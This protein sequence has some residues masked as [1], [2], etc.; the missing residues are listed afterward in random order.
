VRLRRH[1]RLCRL[2]FEIRLQIYHYCI[3]RKYVIRVSSPRFYIQRLFQEKDYPVDLENV[4]DFEDD[5]LGLEGTRELGFDDNI[6]NSEADVVYSLGYT[7][8][9]ESNY[10]NC[11]VILEGC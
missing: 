6:E 1:L 7:F 4:L 8:D 3:P 5:T 9:M 11:T 2:P 10:W